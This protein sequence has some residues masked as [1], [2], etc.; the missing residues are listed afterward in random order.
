[1]A[2]NKKGMVGCLFYNKNFF[3]LHKLA[4]TLFST[5]DGANKKKHDILRMANK[6]LHRQITRD[7]HFFVLP[8]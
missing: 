4:S 7:E 3:H 5:H 6:F 8:N 1:M 2:E